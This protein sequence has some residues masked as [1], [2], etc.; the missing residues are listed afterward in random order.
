VQETRTRRVA[1]PMTRDI[2][3]IVI[4][5][6]VEVFQQEGLI[7]R[8]EMLDLGVMEIGLDSLA[9]AVLV[10]RLQVKLGRDPFTENPNLGY[11]KSLE[12]FI[13]AYLA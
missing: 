10:A 1:C 6:I 13:D 3:E 9:Y 7:F 2:R 5:E 8:D 4:Q 12:Q 11:P